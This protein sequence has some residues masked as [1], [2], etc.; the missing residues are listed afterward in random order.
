MK[1][2]SKSTPAKTNFHFK[3]EFFEELLNGIPS[4]DFEYDDKKNSS[5]VLSPDNKVRF[6]HVVKEILSTDESKQIFINLI[7]NAKKREQAKFLID[8][9]LFFLNK[10]DDEDK[11]EDDEE[12]EEIGEKEKKQNTLSKI[13]DIKKISKLEK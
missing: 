1:S 5:V 4:E 6:K 12:I 11:D 7:K 9:D 13:L 8:L 2:K 10:D 3:D